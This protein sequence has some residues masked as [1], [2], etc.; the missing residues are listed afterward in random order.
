MKATHIDKENE[1]KHASICELLEMTNEEKGQL[2]FIHLKAQYH[3]AIAE[4]ARLHSQSQGSLEHAKKELQFQITLR[5][6]KQELDKVTR[7]N[8]QLTKIVMDLKEGNNHLCQSL[9]KAQ[10]DTKDLTIANIKLE[11]EIYDK[12]E[13]S[14]ENIALQESKGKDWKKRYSLL[15]K[16]SGL[17]MD[18]ECY[19]TKGWKHIW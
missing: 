19:N 13:I 2:E 7:R 8:S 9:D 10:K 3:D 4:N 11:H 12:K 5:N 1:E 16:S 18:R 14:Q 17:H 6:I 15:G